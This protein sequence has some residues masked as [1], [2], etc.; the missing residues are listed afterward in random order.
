M[1][2]DKLVYSCY[3]PVTF[4]N[5]GI[6][7]AN[8]REFGNTPVLNDKFIRVHNGSAISL[9]RSFSIVIGKLLGP[10]AL[11]RLKFFNILVTS[12]GVVEDKNNVFV[13]LLV[14]KELKAFLAF[15]IFLSIFPAIDVKKL[16]K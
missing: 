12:P 10:T 5:T 13:L 2:E 7:L 1:I 15:A 3:I 6:T 16:L 4:L 11:F 8:F 14:K 9:F